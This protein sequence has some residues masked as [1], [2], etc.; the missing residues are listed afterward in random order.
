MKAIS[1]HQPFASAIFA[2]LKTY[3]TRGWKCPPSIGGTTILIHAAKF[4]PMK[5][6]LPDWQWAELTQAMRGKPMPLGALLGIAVVAGCLPTD[7]IWNQW[8]TMSTPQFRSTWGTEFRWGN[9]EPGRFMWKLTDVLAFDNPIPYKGQ[10]GF[11]EVPTE[12]VVNR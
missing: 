3:E 12:A 10:Q 2:G 7:P 1:L 11:F 5:Y 6:D 8:N 9:Y 4:D